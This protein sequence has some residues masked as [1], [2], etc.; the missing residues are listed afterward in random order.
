MKKTALITGASSGIGKQF[1]H[2]HAERGGN[3]VI[4]ART[5]VKLLELKKEL[6]QKYGTKVLVIAKDLTEP[7]APKEIYEDIKFAGIQ[8]DYLMNNAGFGGIG[9]FHERDLEKDLGMIDLNVRAL[10]ALTH[11]FL[12]DFVARNEGRI[13]NV[14]ST[15]SL[16]AGPLQ[17][18]YF[19]TKA[20]VT[21]FTNAIAEEL[22]GTNITVTNLMPG[23]TETQ[24]GAVS[25]MDKTSMFEST[26]S[27]RS[28][29][30][31]GYNGMLEG[32]LDVTS[33]LTFPQKMMVSLIPVTPK[34]MLLKQVKKM[35][36]VD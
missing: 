22:R 5:E 32:E 25:G 35:Q 15:A 2:I 30:E 12:K 8:V 34:K 31:D 24:F 33:G 20:Y 4:V 6:E 13:L 21:S 1:A 29:A 7:N 28:V 9:A 3:L 27:A 19:A 23:A 26:A 11:N 16:M 36:E 17:A 18:V 14:S 10:T